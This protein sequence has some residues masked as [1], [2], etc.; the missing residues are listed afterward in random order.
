M[1]RSSSPDLGRLNRWLT[2]PNVLCI[3]RFLGSWVMLWFAI[4]EQPQWVV[5]IFLFLTA[6]DWIDGKVA[7]FL[8]QRSLIGPK[9]DTIADVTMYGCL[10]ISMLRLQHA[11][12]IAEV[13]YFIA[14]IASYAGSCLFSIFKFHRIP[15]YHTRAAKTCW[16]LMIFAVCALFVGWSIWPL[17]IAM[18]GVTLTNLE[19]IL[20]TYRS[21]ESL[22]DI[23]HAEWFKPRQRR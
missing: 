19:A 2:V 4:H 23:K 14:A 20:I 6:T 16:L 11:V 22:S 21:D 5:G 7:R 9:L 15:S 10:L 18:V 17:R 1:S 12:L 8:D 13:E 3:V